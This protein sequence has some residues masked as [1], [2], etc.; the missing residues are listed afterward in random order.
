MACMVYF[1]VMSILVFGEFE[2]WDFMAGIACVVITIFGVLYLQRQNDHSYGNLFFPKYF[3]L[4]WVVTVRMTLLSIPTIVVLYALASILGD[5]E[6]L[7]PA[8]AIFTIGYE[9]I[10]FWWL[11]SLIAESNRAGP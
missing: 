8:G 6:V 11:G 2:R 7:N 1:S 10:F 5:R 3:C 4:G 9:I